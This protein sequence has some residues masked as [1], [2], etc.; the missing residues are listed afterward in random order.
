MG[1]AKNWSSFL[2]EESKARRPSPLKA[3]ANHLTIPGLISLGGGFLPKMFLKANEK[4][5]RIQD[6]F[7]SNLSTF[8]SRRWGN[9]KNP[10]SS[11]TDQQ[12]V[13]SRVQVT[14][15]HRQEQK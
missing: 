13:L 8:M 1:M 2:S 6:I 14:Q 12:F 7:P 9:S 4:D 5:S 11:M 3:I 15:L 10:K